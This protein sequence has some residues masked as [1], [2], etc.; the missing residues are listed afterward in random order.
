LLILLI[1]I[2][3]SLFLIILVFIFSFFFLWC[4]STDFFI[5][6]FFI[7]IS[8][9][10]FL[11]LSIILILIL[12]IITCPWSIR[13]S[14]VDVLSTRVWSLNLIDW[15]RIFRC[16]FSFLSINKL[17]LCLRSSR[18]ISFCSHLDLAFSL[19]HCCLRSLFSFINFLRSLV[20][21]LRSF[22]DN[23]DFFS[24]FRFFSLI[25]WFFLL[26]LNNFKN[27]IILFW[28]KNLFNF[29]ISSWCCSGIFLLPL[30][31]S[32][33]RRLFVFHGVSKLKTSPRRSKQILNSN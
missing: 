19:H 24:F 20:L 32:L 8:W 9:F 31:F 21:L 25:F 1:L 23:F 16:S 30:L 7:V 27:F 22:F 14:L 12:F 13:S 5:F 6:I 29:R 26:C 4:L 17:L 15:C 28:L 2:A 10:S 3:L 18:S 33:S 11:C